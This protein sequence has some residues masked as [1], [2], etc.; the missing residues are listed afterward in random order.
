MR[1]NSPSVLVHEFFSGGGCQETTIPPDIA[2][3]GLAMLTALL[4]DFRRWGRFRT[5]TTLDARLL[6]I[7]LPADRVVRVDHVGYQDTLAALI[8][9][10]RL[11]LLVAPENDG[12]L[13]SLSRLC[14][15]AGVPLL[16]SLSN[17]A[18]IAGDK[19]GCHRI[20][21]DAGIPTPPTWHVNS[22]T[23]HR[24]AGEAG[25]PLVI[26]PIDGAGSEGVGLVK[27]PS[28]LAQAM[29]KAIFKDRCF[30]LQRYLD[31]RHFSVSLLVSHEDAV[32]LSLNE[33]H[34]HIGT[35]FVYQGGRILETSLQ[36]HPAAGTARRAVSL[37]PGLRGWVGV[38]MVQSGGK[39]YVIEIN[40][41]ITTAYV[42]LRQAVAVNLAE[43]I[44]RACRKGDLQTFLT[45]DKK[46]S[47]NK[48][49]LVNA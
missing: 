30:L 38:D 28:S 18:D 22:E 15:Q 33:Q 42:G 17:G 24:V 16:G 9:Q 36:G 8:A 45:L 41:R 27:D 3:E 35:S 46:V 20:L 5:L 1:W 39:W 40:P 43:A 2:G 47:F 37:M 26:K 11:V 25:F 48:E 49:K 29:Q 7:A 34:I 13:S 10:S 12:M 14:E 31:G 4:S 44:W 6:N 21:T 19:W 23:A 32:A